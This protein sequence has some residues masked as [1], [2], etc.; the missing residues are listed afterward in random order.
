MAV[1]LAVLTVAEKVDSLGVCS[2]EKR[3][4]STVEMLAVEWGVVWAAT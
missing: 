2:A 4:V 1:S 3:A